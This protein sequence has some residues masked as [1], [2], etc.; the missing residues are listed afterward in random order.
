MVVATDLTANRATRVSCRWLDAVQEMFDAQPETVLADAGYCNERDLKDLEK[1][2]HPRFRG[3]RF[4]LEPLA[5]IGAHLIDPVTGETVR[6]L[7][8]ALD[9]GG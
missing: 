3:R 7:L 2:P 6:A 8:A 5:A 9:S 4:V 1:L